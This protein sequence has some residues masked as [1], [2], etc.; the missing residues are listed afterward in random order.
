MPYRQ[1][2]I[3][4][5]VRGALVPVFALYLVATFVGLT[6]TR[7]V[8]ALAIVTRRTSGGASSS[9]ALAEAE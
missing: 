9:V 3:M 8:S 7:W 5:S 4:S 2:M 1:T 6:L